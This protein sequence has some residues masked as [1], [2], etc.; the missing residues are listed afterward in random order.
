MFCS[1]N[2]ELP[3]KLR[4][5]DVWFAS[6]VCLFVTEISLR[7]LQRQIAWSVLNFTSLSETKT[8]FK[9]GSMPARY[10]GRH[11]KFSLE[12]NSPLYP[13]SSRVNTLRTSLPVLKRYIPGYLA[14]LVAPF[15]VPFI[16][17]ITPNVDQ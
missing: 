6:A 10:T 12:L 17:S 7:R 4:R 13:A 3:S 2:S 1:R 14:N 9:E 15:C 8:F 11:T 16:L 5:T